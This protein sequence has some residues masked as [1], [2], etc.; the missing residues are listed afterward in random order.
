MYMYVQV[1][2]LSLER[3]Q[4]FE[5]KTLYEIYEGPSGDESNWLLLKDGDFPVMSRVAYRIF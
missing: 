5:D 3:L 2:R 1:I 4:I